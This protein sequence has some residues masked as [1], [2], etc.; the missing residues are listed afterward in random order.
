[1]KQGLIKEFLSG[2]ESLEVV[3]SREQGLAKVTGV[4][5]L[6]NYECM[7]MKSDGQ[8]EIGVLVNSM[9][10]IMVIMNCKI[11]AKLNIINILKTASSMTSSDLKVTKYLTP[12]ELQQA[13]WCPC[14]MGEAG[15]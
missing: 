13:G 3:L 10:F 4:E 12:G 14:A 1:M 8:T 7:V 11:V 9:M 5:A 15:H 6:D 2:T